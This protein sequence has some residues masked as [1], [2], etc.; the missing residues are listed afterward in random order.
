[1]KKNALLTSAS[2][3]SVLLFAL[4]V[5]DDIVRGFEKGGPENLGAIPILVI[6]LCG[7]LLLAERRVGLVIVLLG[8]ILGTG[9]PVLHFNSA[10][11]IVGRGI[12]QSPGA[13][14]WVW[15]LLALGTSSAFSGIIAVQG[16]WGMRKRTG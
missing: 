6:W 3:L 13:L 11:G 7:A 1:M 4:H 2:L 5:S 16:L 15:T 8:A 14:L 10:A 9:V 12:A